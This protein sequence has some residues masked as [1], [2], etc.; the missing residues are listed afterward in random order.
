M[1]VEPA[2]I[3][4]EVGVYG[5]S[6]LIIN[7]QDV[8]SN[9]YGVELLV[10]REGAPIC[11]VHYAS[12]N[13]KLSGPGIVHVPGGDKDSV[14]AF[15]ESVSPGEIE[16]LALNDDEWGQTSPGESFVKALLKVAEDG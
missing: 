11:T 16:R 10:S 6:K 9:A 3:E 2:N 14:K 5:L 4:V 1:A 13:V 15:L 8:T 12:G 7:G